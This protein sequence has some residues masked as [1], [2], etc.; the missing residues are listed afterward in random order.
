[1][2]T[3]KDASNN[4]IKGD[5]KKPP[6]LMPGVHG[7]CAAVNRGAD[8]S[9]AI[10]KKIMEEFVS[11][12]P[13]VAQ[14]IAKLPCPDETFLFDR[15]SNIQYPFWAEFQYFLSNMVRFGNTQ[16]IARKLS[17][18]ARLSLDCNRAWGNW[19]D[20]RS[21]QFEV[22]A[23]FL[24]ERYFEG[25]ITQLIPEGKTPT[26]DFMVRLNQGEFRVEAK[27][28]SGQQRG[29][30]HPRQDGAILFDP[31]EEIDLRSWLFEEKNSSRNGKVME[32][33]AI[34]AE[35]KGAEILICQTDY[36][37]TESNLLSQLS[38][39]CPQNRFVEKMTLESTDRK[40]IAVTSDLVTYHFR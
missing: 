18:V 26:S 20:F 34:A 37:A 19:C 24:I 30:I 7:G 32:P 6:R 9:T 11:L 8:C 40:P 39:L 29:D 21:S 4:G 2:R 1:L 5:G 27:A 35:K 17:S 33:M 36:V 13:R 38:V 28:Q 3:I 31:K 23:I 15:T 14:F 22:T 25:E 10:M 12:Y 16:E